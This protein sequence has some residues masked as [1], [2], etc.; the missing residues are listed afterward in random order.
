MVDARQGLA[1]PLD[2]DVSPGSSDPTWETCTVTYTRRVLRGSLEG[3]GREQRRSGPGTRFNRPW[4]LRRIF[5]S[6]FGEEKI[7]GRPTRVP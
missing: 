1:C 7:N 5:E 6:E 3:V 2:K 4:T